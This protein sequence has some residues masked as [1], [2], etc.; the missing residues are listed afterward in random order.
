MQSDT[1]LTSLI[2]QAEP[3]GKGI[4]GRTMRLDVAG[5]RVFVKCIPMTDLELA[6]EHRGSTANLFDLPTFTHYGVGSPGGGAWRELATH[7]MTTDWVLTGHHGSFP[8]LYHWRVLPIPTTVA[9]DEGL[10]DID[11]LVEY[12]EGSRAVR[13]RLEALA[14][15]TSSLVLLLEYVPWSLD[16]WLMRQF[17]V[18]NAEPACAFVEE[19]LRDDVSAMNRRGLMHFDAH[20]RNILTDGDQLYLSDFGLASSTRFDLTIAERDFLVANR[21][22]DIA[23]AAALLVNFIV[24]RMLPTDVAQRNELIRRLAIGDHTRALPK[25]LTAILDRHAP[26]AV[27]INDFYWKLFGESRATPYP[28]KAIENLLQEAAVPY[29]DPG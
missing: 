20:L 18:G 8:M 17:E 22:H 3:A 5:V 23:Y 14:A 15:A 29:T 11:S 12:W 24:S 21:T 6:P 9:A 26:V 1:Q 27:E 28:T 2:D 13:T 7:A 16:E 19:H 10:E 25:A 4:G